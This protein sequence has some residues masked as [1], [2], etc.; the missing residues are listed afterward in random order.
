MLDISYGIIP[1]IHHE[2]KIYTILVKLASGN[3]RWLPKGHPEANE[4]PVQTAIR[5]LHEETGL[6]VSDDQI[7]TS[8]VYTESYSFIHPTRGPIDKTVTYSIA[9]IAYPTDIYLWSHEWS[10]ILEKRLLTLDEAIALV[11][12]DATREVLRKL[13]RNLSA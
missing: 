12:Y 7:N 9:H 10:E 5:E 2:D 11:T 1:L 4:T 6:T 3:H 13:K 8:Q